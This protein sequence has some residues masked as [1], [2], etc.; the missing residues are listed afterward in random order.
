MSR[1]IRE[2]MI[3]LT[4]GIGVLLLYRDLTVTPPFDLRK[5]DAQIVGQ[6]DADMW[7]S[8]YERRPARLLLQMTHLLREQYRLTYSQS[9]LA[10]LHATR[11]AFIFKDGNDSTYTN[12][13]PSLRSY[14]RILLPKQSDDFIQQVAQ[15]ELGW[16]ILHR[17]HSPQLSKSLEDLQAHLYE[18]PCAKFTTHAKLRAEAMNLRDTKDQSITNEDW[19][20]ISARLRASW[21]ELWH[22]VN[23]APAPT[24]QTT[25]N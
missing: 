17:Q 8:Y 3:I 5:F 4:V 6:L 10:A 1:K 23:D 11:A 15:L 20:K 24:T 14:Y 25:R 21:T 19:A 18:M 7:R 22:A 2:S 9:W 16:W 13:L 12:A